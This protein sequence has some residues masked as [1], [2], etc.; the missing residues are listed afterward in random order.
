MFAG[1]LAAGLV[2]KKMEKRLNLGWLFFATLFHDFLLGI[3]VL[4][5]WEQ[6]HIPS[7]FAQT[8]YLTFTFPYSHGLAASM[9]WS[10][11]VFGI[12]YALLPRWS[13]NERQQAGGGLLPFCFGL[14]GSYPR[15][16]PAWK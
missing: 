15:A 7:N 12:T 10:G 14:A 6:I 5:G 2:L 9:V 13:A 3:L 4:L 16:A 11:L 1:H 8:H